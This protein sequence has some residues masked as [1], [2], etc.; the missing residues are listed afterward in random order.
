MPDR[1]A[2]VMKQHPRTREVHHFTDS[3]PHFRFVAMDRA[4]GAGGFSFLKRAVF[5]LQ[6]GVF[7]QFPTGWA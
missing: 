2:W 6:E 4:F 1:Q 5:Q 7:F 3:H